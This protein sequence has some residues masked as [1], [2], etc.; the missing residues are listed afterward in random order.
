[1]GGGLPKADKGPSVGA[2]KLL[3][4]Y[5][6]TLTSHMPI[7][8]NAANFSS[9]S[10]HY[11]FSFHLVMFLHPLPPMLEVPREDITCQVAYEKGLVTCYITLALTTCPNRIQHASRTCLQMPRWK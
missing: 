9:Q 5:G 11:P 6:A 1:M 3:V 8:V 4:E 10:A 2:F 7:V